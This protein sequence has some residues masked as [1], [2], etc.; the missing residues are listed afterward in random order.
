MPLSSDGFERPET[1]EL[2]GS[3]R[4]IGLKHGRFLAPKIR[5]Q[6]QVYTAMFRQTSHLSWPDV[7]IIAEAYSE[8]IR[9]LTPDLHVEMA[10]IADG[11]DLELLDIVALNCRSEIALGL[12]SDGCTSLGWKRQSGEVLLAQNWDWTERV[13]E[14]L[15]MM[16]IEQP[17]KPKIYMVTE[18]GIIGKIGFN[19]SSVGTNLNAIRARPTDP[20][21]LPIHVAL[22]VCLE[23]SS[24]A[25]AIST[26]ESLGGIASSAHILLA[27]ASGPISLEL[28]PQ[29]NTYIEPS[30]RGIICHT[31]HFI[32]N[33][34][35]QEP[36]WLSGSPIRLARCQQLTTEL[37]ESGIKV[38][39]EVL[40]ERVFSD[41]F[42]KPEAICCEEDPKRAVE[43]RSS[44]LFNIVMKFQTGVDASGEV[45]W[46]RPGSGEEGGV[47]RMPW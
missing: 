29:G 36:E 46:G 4:E 10:G 12:F 15:V 26:L 24:T 13:K 40:R 7:R 35:V 6:I 19:T 30:I 34:F 31:N 23:S 11:A 39:A 45:V 37:D 2:S 21:K 28:S 47:L 33:R 38:D 3:P 41:G 14:N 9:K 18:A 16:S 32:Q 22:R 44:T 27:D 17:K 42:N 20:S 8:T 5:S 1:I 43:T 25:S